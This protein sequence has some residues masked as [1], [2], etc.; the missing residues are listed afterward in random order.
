[1]RVTL[2]HTFAAY[3]WL[4]TTMD[5]R[6]L[7]RLM[8]CGSLAMHPA[9]VRDLGYI[10][11]RDYL[12]PGLE[13]ELL[14]TSS[15]ERPRPDLI[16]YHVSSRDYPRESFVV[17]D[18]DVQIVSPELSFWQMAKILPLGELVKYGDALCGKYSFALDN[19]GRPVKREVPLTTVERIGSFI[20]AMGKG[21]ANT[22]ALRALRF[23]VEGSE[24]PMESDVTILLCLKRQYGGFGFR[25]PEMGHVVELDDIGK[26]IYGADTCRCDMYWQ[27]AGYDLEYDSDQEHGPGSATHDSLRR[28]A[29]RHMGIT[30]GELRAPQITDSETFVAT[31]KLLAKDLRISIHKRS[32]ELEYKY[33][34]A[35]TDLRRQLFWWERRD[36]G[37]DPSPLRVAELNW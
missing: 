8:R 10:N 23:I 6:G 29:I 24:S 19:E 17:L 20:H 32:D 30:V 4:M 34:I 33:W 9:T 16:H 22:A 35:Y 36:A 13:T 25:R 27:H 5:G 12:V 31:A 21:A 37:S 11:L 3:H 26:R 18:M 7:D 1:M 28:T 14:S 15:S 2:T